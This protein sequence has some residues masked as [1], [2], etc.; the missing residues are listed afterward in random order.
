MQAIENEYIKINFLKEESLI[1]SE[2]FRSVSSEEYRAGVSMSF[3]LLVECNPT[4]WLIDARHLQGIRMADQ[5]WV[6]QECIPQLNGLNLRKIARIGTADIFHYMSFEDM[7]QKAAEENP[8]D[9]DV[10]QFTS[11]EAAKAWLQLY[12]G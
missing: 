11:V 3:R 1:H 9:I 12:E 4:F 10:A 5:H 6:Q 8:L 7:A 2:W